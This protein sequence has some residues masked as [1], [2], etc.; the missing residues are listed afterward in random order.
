[1]QFTDLIQLQVLKRKE[2]FPARAMDQILNRS[3]DPSIKQL[4]AKVHVSLIQDLDEVCALLD[5]SKR[6]FIEAAL[7]DALARAHDA[8]DSSG[9]LNDLAPK[10]GSL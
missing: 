8:I 7:V 10:Q 4:C 6:Q 1:M 9:I 5:M 2:T 3:E